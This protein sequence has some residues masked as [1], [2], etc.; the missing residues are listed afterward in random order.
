MSE[1]WAAIEGFVGEYAISD[2]GRVMS[3]NFAKSGL[4]G[5]MKPRMVRRYM[6][7]CIGRK[8][9]Y[10]HH[11]VAHAFI[12]EKPAGMQVNHKDGDRENNSASNLEYVT[13]S[14]NIKHA[15]RLRLLD[16]RGEKHSQSRL[17][18]ANVYQILEHI[19]NGRPIVAIAT[20]FGVHPS[21]ISHIKAGR[22]W[23]HI[24]RRVG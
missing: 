19:G 8:S 14:E 15:C 4:P 16:N 24:S 17:T 6:I 12:G 21:Q 9:K 11:L 1:K 5:I 2:A 7:V 18:E 20:E 23:P 10:V 22:S 13:P 3:M